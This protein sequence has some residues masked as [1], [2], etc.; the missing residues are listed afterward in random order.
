M[1]LNALLASIIM[2]MEQVSYK[3]ILK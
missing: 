2:L 3:F 1:L